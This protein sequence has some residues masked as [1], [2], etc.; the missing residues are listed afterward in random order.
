MNRRTLNRNQ[1]KYLAAF[2][3]LL[4]HIAWAFVPTQSVAGE[5]MHMVGRITAPVMLFFLAEGYVYT[6][7]LRRY[8]GRLGLFAL[9]SW[10]PCSLFE[11]GTWP[12]PYLGMIYTMLLGLLAVWIWD[13]SGLSQASRFIV[14]L[15]LCFLSLFGD[16]PVIGVVLPVVFFILREREQEKWR[17]YFVISL[18]F[19][20]SALLLSGLRQLF[21]SGMLLAP[22]LLKR[23][24]G[25]AGSRT[26]FH[27]WFFYVFYPAH[28]LLLWCLKTFL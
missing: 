14:M 22:L 10:P 8:A 17:V 11:F 12:A 28:I 7:N 16:W 9:I 27:K 3:M 15:C 18:C 24:N 6:H 2:A 20:I 4:D 19:L 25:E 1:L 13:R 26:P 23:Y 21:Q 5:L